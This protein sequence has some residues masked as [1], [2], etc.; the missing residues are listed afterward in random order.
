MVKMAQDFSRKFYDSPQWRACRDYILRR[1]HFIC[2]R[3]HEKPA[4]IVH[5]IVWLT[6]SNINDPT[7]TLGED[8]LMSVCR[9]CH[10]IIHEGVQATLDGLYFDEKGNLK[11]HESFDIS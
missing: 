4:D 6:P 5:H 10:A 9:D 3:C 2:Q 1:D 11:K 7:I 8:N